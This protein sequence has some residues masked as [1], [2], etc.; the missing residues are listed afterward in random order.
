MTW[1]CAIHPEHEKPYE[2]RPMSDGFVV[3]LSTTFETPLDYAG[4]IASCLNAM[5]FAGTMLFDLLLCN[6]NVYNRFVKGTFKDGEIDYSSMKVID[7][8]EISDAVLDISTSFY[9]AN[10][11]LLEKSYILLDEDKRTLACG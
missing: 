1:D 4:E 3:V 10:K 8:V 2:I 6:G 5:G 9:R 7:H 11:A